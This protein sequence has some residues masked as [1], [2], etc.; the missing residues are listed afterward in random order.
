LDV[1]NDADNN[2]N[3]DIVEQNAREESDAHSDVDDDTD[4]D[5]DAIITWRSLPLSRYKEFLRR[6]AWFATNSPDFN[7]DKIG[8]NGKI[9]EDKDNSSIGSISSGVDFGPIIEDLQLICQNGR[10]RSSTG[11]YFTVD[12]NFFFTESDIRFTV[13]HFPGSFFCQYFEGPWPNFH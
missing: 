6:Q 12:S 1:D 10:I 2:D 4:D 3:D 9:D 5:D 11:S 8:N 13:Q 7:G